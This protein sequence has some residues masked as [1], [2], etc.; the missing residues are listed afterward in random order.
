MNVTT[1]INFVF[2]VALILVSLLM[3]I[4]FFASTKESKRKEKFYIDEIHDVMRQID[5]LTEK[6]EENTKDRLA[7]ISLQLEKS[8][9][10][11]S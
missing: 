8:V 9:K 5:I 4:A 3:G 10:K 2:P 7:S 1:I 6:V 11:L